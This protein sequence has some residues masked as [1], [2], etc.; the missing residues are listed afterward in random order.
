MPGVYIQV[1]FR[2]VSNLDTSW[3]IT[4][5]NEPDPDK[6]RKMVTL[7]DE[8]TSD[9]IEFRPDEGSIDSAHVTTQRQG[10]APMLDVEIRDGETV[11]LEE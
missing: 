3:V 11:D 2:N 6:C 4:D 1:R 5:L 10:Q 8:E 7:S 9:P